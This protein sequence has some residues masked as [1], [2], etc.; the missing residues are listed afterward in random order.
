[1]LPRSSR[2][3]ERPLHRAFALVWG[4]VLVMMMFTLSYPD[5]TEAAE[6]PLPLALFAEEAFFAGG[7]PE[8][9]AST[10]GC[11]RQ[12][13][14]AAPAIDPQHDL[15][16]LDLAPDRTPRLGC[17]AAHALVAHPSGAGRS[18]STHALLRPPDLA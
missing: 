12:H 17:G 9:A 10:A 7:A 13:A 6:Q 16:D 1:M 11:T 2:R 18:A 4:M 3:I 15:P 5:C 14:Q 8:I